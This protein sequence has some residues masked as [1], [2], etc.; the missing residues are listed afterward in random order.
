MGN[1]VGIIGAVAC[2][3][4]IVDAFTSK[5]FLNTYGSNPVVCVAARAVLKIYQDE[6]LMENSY[7][8]G[9]QINEAVSRLCEEYPQVYREIR[10]EGLF[11][12][13]EI[14]GDTPEHSG[15]VA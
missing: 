10:G 11:Q 13:L 6:G 14:A 8:R 15:E 1:G 9:L 5:M 2:K 7:Q 3:R 4:S 12:G